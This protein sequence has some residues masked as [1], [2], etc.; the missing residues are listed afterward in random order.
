MTYL[1]MI[2][3]GVLTTFIVLLIINEGMS[4]PPGQVWVHKR[5]MLCETNPSNEFVKWYEE[6]VKEFNYQIPKSYDPVREYL[7]TKKVIIYD[8]KIIVYKNELRQLCEACGC[9]TQYI[10]YYLVSQK[11]VSE[12]NK[13]GFR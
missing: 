5:L 3:V 8:Y 10:P 6:K 11:N 1:T 9:G 12:L 4:A 2:G 13:L 7:K